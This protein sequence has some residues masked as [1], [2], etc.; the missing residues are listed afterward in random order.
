MSSFGKQDCD[1]ETCDMSAFESGLK[2]ICSCVC[3]K[4]SK[5]TLRSLAVGIK[6]KETKNTLQIMQ[7]VK[8]DIQSDDKEK[9]AIARTIC[10]NVR[11]HIAENKRSDDKTKA[12]WTTVKFN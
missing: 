1:C 12:R 6:A 10:K 2:V 8:T 3:H 9:K 5:T 4:V 11:E 7:K